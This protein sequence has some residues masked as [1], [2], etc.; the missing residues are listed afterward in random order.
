MKEKNTSIA[1]SKVLCIICP[2]GCSISVGERNGQRSFQGGCA[3]G[4][5]YA[6]QEVTHPCRVLTT[7]VRIR[8]GEIPRLPV[9]T[10]RPFPKEL[11]FALV[12]SLRSFEVEAPVKRGDVLVRNLLGTGV[13]LIAT[14]TIHRQGKEEGDSKEV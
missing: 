3:R 11:M 13:D 12:E 14:R 4:R 10:S 9:R 2:L 5:A 6:E 7:T 8:N 1:S